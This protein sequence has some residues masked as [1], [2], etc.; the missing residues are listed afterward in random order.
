VIA[1]TLA[2]LLARRGRTVLALDSDMLP[3]LTLSLGAPAPATPPLMDAAERDE[4]GRWRLK[5]G[6]GPVRAVQRYAT[7]APDGVRLMQAG[8]VG[9]DGLPAIMPALQAYYRVV[10]RLRRSPAFATWDIV[11]DLPAGPRQTAFDWAPYADRFVLVVEPT[12][13]SLLTARRIGRIA[14]QR[15]PVALIAVANKVRAGEDVER[16]E[17]F[18]GLPVH[19]AIPAD[20][21]VTAAERRGAAL[22]DETPGAPAVAAVERLADALAGS[23][24]G[25]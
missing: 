12:S 10:H 3:G 1:G 14:T 13:Q 25:P 18:L 9:P 24:L 21:A 4:D 5:R 15:R 6:V 11:G 2:R 20:P 22:L 8:K 7:E 17:R 19:V 23:R 16:I